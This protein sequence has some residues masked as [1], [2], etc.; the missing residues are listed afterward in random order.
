M[1]RDEAINRILG[2][3]RSTP[4]RTRDDTR[5]FEA[6]EMAIEALKQGDVLQEIR[7][8]IINARLSDKDDISKAN[9]YGL[10]T[11]LVIIDKYIKGNWMGDTE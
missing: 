6:L 10:N 2:I 3:E 8:E 9:N 11:A 4:I 5:D 7:Q 1:T